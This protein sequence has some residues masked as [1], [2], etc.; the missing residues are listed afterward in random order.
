MPDLSIL[1]RL[2]RAER[3]AASAARGIADETISLE[4]RRSK[5]AAILHSVRTSAASWSRYGS[6]RGVSQEDW[7]RAQAARAD[8]LREV[9]RLVRD[10][11]TDVSQFMSTLK[12]ASE[13]GEADFAI[14][15]TQ[16]EAALASCE[17]E[18]AELE[19]ERARRGRHLREL[20]ASIRLGTDWLKANGHVEAAY[21]GVG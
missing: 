21:A 14:A 6:E 17:R 12:Q 9:R 20:R 1:R 13:P 11:G 7:M 8:Q 16:A 18:L 2:E 4:Q 19:T 15:I 10:T 3:A 5:L